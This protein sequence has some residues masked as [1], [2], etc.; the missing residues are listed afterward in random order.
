MYL[1]ID[2]G[3]SSSKAA[4]LNE[5]KE[6]VSVSAVNLG[7]GTNGIE[8]ALAQ[9]LMQAGICGQDIKYTVATGYGRL[10]YAPADKQ[11][12]EKIGRAHV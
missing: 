10:K 12:T 9:A 5:Q 2:I 8:T 7:T 3:S 11:I 4:I 6:L 1:G